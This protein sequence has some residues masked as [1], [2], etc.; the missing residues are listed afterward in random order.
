MPSGVSRLDF[1]TSATA[2]ARSGLHAS[3]S[4]PQDSSAT[5]ASLAASGAG[6]PGA[7]RAA[8]AST[9][10]SRAVTTSASSRLRW[11]SKSIHE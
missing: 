4:F 3:S 7:P 10:R 5:L 8:R 6:V 2:A 11:R 1:A 9:L